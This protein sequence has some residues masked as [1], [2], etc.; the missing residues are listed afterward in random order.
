MASFQNKTLLIKERNKETCEHRR[1]VVGV[2]VV[3]EPVV[4]P[5]PLAVVPVQ[6]QDIAVATRTAKDCMECLLCHHP[7]NPV[8]G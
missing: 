6:V 8:R 4:V 5:V 7:L 2:P 1:R 3:V